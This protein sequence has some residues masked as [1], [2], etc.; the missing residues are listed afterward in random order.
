[1]RSIDQ[2]LD[3]VAVARRATDT[4]ALLRL[5]EELDELQT[6]QAEANALRSRGTAYFHFGD[7]LQALDHFKK[8]LELFED[9]GD[10]IGIARVLQGIG[11]VHTYRGDTK[12]A[13]DCLHRSLALGKETGDRAVEAGCITNMSHIY[14]N[15]GDHTSALEHYYRALEIYEELGDQN[16]VA[17][18]LCNI[19]LTLSGIDDYPAALEHLYRAL[20]LSTEVG[21]KRW[22]ANTLMNIGNIFDSTGVHTTALEYYNK[23]AA[24]YEE[25]GDKGGI[26]SVTTAIGWS[27]QNSGDLDNALEYHYRA[28][29]M[30]QEI[31]QTQASANDLCN[32]ILVLLEK[33]LY[34]EARPHLETMD[35]IKI[36]DPVLRIWREQC[37]AQIQAGTGDLDD[38]VTTLQ[39]ALVEANAHNLRAKAAD[40][41]KALRDLAQQR[42]DLAGY[43][44]HNNEHSRIISEING[45][46]TA[47]RLATQE[48]E[49]RIASERQEHQRH[50]AILHS[51]LPRHI[52]DR[53]ARGEIV[54][55]HFD[56]A[57]VLFLDVVG[58]TSQSS[59]LGAAAVVELLQK[60]FTAFDDICAI[61]E[62]TKIKTIGDSYMAVA[63]PLESSSSEQEVARHEQRAANVAHAMMAT[64]F[65]WPNG[66]PVQFRIGLHCG[67]VVAG[68]LGTERMQ[69]DVWGDTVNVASRME[70]S[71]EP[72][73]I[74]AS[75]AFVS[76][77]TS[78]PGPLSSLRGGTDLTPL[79]LERGGTEG[80]GVRF[81]T[82]LRG[83]LDIKG[84][85][86]MTT[87]WLETSH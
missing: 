54:N 5:A 58:F 35:T 62:V 45:K 61:H 82:T 86:T 36:D 30:H 57:A 64:S 37:R 76:A 34:N 7:Y 68:V 75:E 43:I 74:H 25:L 87:Y 27:L 11:A 4:E 32:V 47:A 78:P 71:G 41:H 22:T 85:G 80:A 67:P 79:E 8:A 1:M 29:S 46:D 14:N 60:I 55:D 48:A 24:I 3:D 23:A 53:V 49:R 28:L 77:L 52:A 21:N 13:L 38:A 50:L 12:L 10:S 20:E 72:G 16:G 44:E 56:N 83:E 40:V 84:K 65:T 51:T 2:I 73:R 31:G 15:T 26:A 18:A 6:P 33:R 9:L 59:T 66:E 39:R 70:S 81:R 17:G 69:Y 63:F 42:N 19:G